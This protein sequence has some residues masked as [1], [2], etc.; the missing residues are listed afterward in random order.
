MRKALAVLSLVFA[1]ALP[2]AAQFETATVLGTVR[3]KSGAVTPGVTV[4]L[5]N[6]DTGM[7]QTKVTD[8]SGGYEFFTVRLGMYR[9]SA[10]LDGFAPSSVDQLRVGVGARQ[11]VDLIL[12]PGGVTEAVEVTAEVSTLE[13]CL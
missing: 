5:L 3:D 4:T 9:V 2:A 11:R 7:T 8:G 6:L 12:S 1:L 10:T 13:S